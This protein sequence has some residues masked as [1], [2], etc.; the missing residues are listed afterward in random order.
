MNVLCCGTTYSTISIQ[1]RIDVAKYVVSHGRC[2]NTFQNNVFRNV[3]PNSKRRYGIRHIP[4]PLNILWNNVFCLSVSKWTLLNKLLHNI[5]Q[6]ENVTEQVFPNS[7]S[8]HPYLSRTMFCR[9]AADEHYRT[10]Y[11]HPHCDAPPASS[12][13]TSRLPPPMVTVLSFF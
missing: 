5:F 10:H 1:I 9:T 4:T 3:Y 13:L 6:S 12:T 2:C 8:T 11:Y 7:I